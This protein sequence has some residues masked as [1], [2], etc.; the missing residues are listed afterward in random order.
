MSI[1]PGLRG[2]AEI[3]VGDADTARSLGSGDVDVL[4]TPRVVALVERATLAALAG[5][6]DAA[7]TTVGSRVELDHLAPSGVGATVRAE[8]TLE[9]VHGRRLVFTATVSE[10]GRVVARGTLTRVEVERARFA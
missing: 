7:R 1:A 10:A 6:L 3:V 9:A 5:R 2:V 8:V 4:G